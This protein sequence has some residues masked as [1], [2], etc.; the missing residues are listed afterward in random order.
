ME[1]IHAQQSEGMETPEER[2]EWIKL[3]L[4]YVEATVN[5]GKLS[6]RM[7]E[8]MKQ[9]TL[10]EDEFDVIQKDVFELLSVGGGDYLHKIANLALLDAGS[11]SALSNSVFAVKRDKI[12]EMV[13]EEKYIPLCTERV[14]KKYYTKSKGDHPNAWTEPDRRAYIN[15]INNVLEPYLTKKKNKNGP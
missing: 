15:A 13:K 10:A 12:K 6:Y 14:F 7:K 3:H 1:H 8:S 5:G 11:N 4:P 2:K 9:E